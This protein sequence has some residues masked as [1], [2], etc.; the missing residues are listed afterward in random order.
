M[1]TDITAKNSTRNASVAFPH[2]PMARRIRH[3][4]D[5]TGN[6]VSRTSAHG[7]AFGGPLNLSPPDSF[8]RRDS[9]Y[10]VLPRR[11][12]RPLPEDRGL[13][14]EKRGTERA[15]AEAGN[16]Q[17]PRAGLLDAAREICEAVGSRHLRD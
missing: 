4:L 10:V 14:A 15:R 7:S 1:R 3:H 6:E 8:H 9:A 13:T 16:R 5:L 2:R 11:A 17:F 12:L